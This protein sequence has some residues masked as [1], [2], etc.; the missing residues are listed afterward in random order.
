MQE[1]KA[2]NTGRQFCSCF[3]QLLGIGGPE[4]QP[5]QNASW[6]VRVGTYVSL[7]YHLLS[8]SSSSSSSHPL[9]LSSFFRRLPVLLLFLFS[10][11]AF[12]L[13]LD[14]LDDSFLPRIHLPSLPSR[15][16]RAPFARSSSSSRLAAF[17][18][19]LGHQGHPP[20]CTRYMVCPIFTHGKSTL[21]R[22]WTLHLPLFAKH[23]RYA[24]LLSCISRLGCFSINA[25]RV[26]ISSQT[27]PRA[28][29]MEDPFCSFLFPY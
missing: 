11:P 7:A 23:H 5:W 1:Q 22:R 3:Y 14:R 12:F 21:K 13:L 16:F 9:S 20:R 8:P 10:E 29:G 2:E 26:K 15:S 17:G 6:G 28:G 18:Y 25:D 4:A 19:H 24:L 27:R